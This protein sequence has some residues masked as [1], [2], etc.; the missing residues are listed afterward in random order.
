MTGWLKL[1]TESANKT[2]DGVIHQLRKRIGGTEQGRSRSV[3]HASDITKPYFCP[4]QEALLDQAGVLLGAP[5]FVGTAQRVTYDMG[6]LTAKNLI[7]NWAGDSV[8]GNWKCRRCNQQRTMTTKPGNGCGHS[9]DC[10]WE[11]REVVFKVEEYGLSG[12][13]D[14]LFNVGVPLLLITE[15]KIMTPTEFDPLM[16]PLPEHRLRTNLYLRLAAQG[17]F[18]Y[19]HMLNLNEGRVLYMSRGHGK[20]NEEHDGEI[21]PFKEYVVKRDDEGLDHILDKSK[22]LKVFRDTGAMPSGI[23]NSIADKAAKNCNMCKQCFSG[24]QPAEQEPIK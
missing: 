8:Y 5:S 13:V 12:S 18:I 4:R 17:K 20:K 22:Q 11:Y 23:C 15:L 10:I 3:L 7:E 6:S 9:Q 2:K 1:A 16:A 21:I 14:A 19:D 24:L